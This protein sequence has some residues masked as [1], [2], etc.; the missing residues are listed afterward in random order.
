MGLNGKKELKG[1]IYLS[2]FWRE[3]IDYLLGTVGDE[4]EQQQLIM[5]SF[6]MLLR[7]MMYVEQHI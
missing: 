5:L 4:V 3:L 2:R 6:L 7:R 1:C